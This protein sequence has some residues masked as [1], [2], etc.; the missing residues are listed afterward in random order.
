MLPEHAR[1]KVL[2]PASDVRSRDG[3]I[4]NSKTYLFELF[5]LFRAKNSKVTAVDDS[6]TGQKADE[7]FVPSVVV[8]D[9][10]PFG[11][12]DALDGHWRDT[13]WG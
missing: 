1:L 6:L 7:Q 11:L 4:L 8:I 13:G 12:G 5:D 2:V 3:S 9:R 10:V